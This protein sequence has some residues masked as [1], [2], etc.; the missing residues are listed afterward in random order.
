MKLFG[1]S[2][3]RYVWPKPKTAHQHSETVMAVSYCGDAFHQHVLGNWSGMCKVDEA[4]YMTIFKENPFLLAKDLRVEW[5][6]TFQEDN[7]PNYTARAT[8]QWF[9]TKNVNV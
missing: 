1:P 5:R 3:K 7:N 8:L 9:K 2:A 4:I 6:F